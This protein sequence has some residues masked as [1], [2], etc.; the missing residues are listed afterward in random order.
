ML[1]IGQQKLQ[2]L[3]R[4]LPKKDQTPPYRLNFRP[5]LC[6]FLVKFAVF[7]QFW[8]NFVAKNSKL[9]NNPKV[10]TYKKNVADLGD[11]HV[12]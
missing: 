1:K 6:P 9:G 5:F 7:A 3:G 8:T 4:T 11:Y 10:V 2:K 12:Y